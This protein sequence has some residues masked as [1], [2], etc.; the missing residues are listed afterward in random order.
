MT[1]VEGL[2]GRLREA[3]AAYDKVHITDAMPPNWSMSS[4]ETRWRAEHQAKLDTAW[5]AIVAALASAPPAT[6]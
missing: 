5:R 3:R 2:E 1:P 4:Y 6:H